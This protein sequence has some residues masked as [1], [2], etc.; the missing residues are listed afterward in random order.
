M[1]SQSKTIAPDYLN[2]DPAPP[3][4]SNNPNFDAPNWVKK[5]EPEV[6]RGFINDVVHALKGQGVTSFAVTRYCFGGRYAIDFAIDQVVD[7]VIVSH[8][9]QVEIPKTFK[10][11]ARFAKAPLLLEMGDQD[12]EVDVKKQGEIDDILGDYAHGHKRE[13]WPGC[14]HGFA[15]RADILDPNNSRVKRGHSRAVLHGWRSISESHLS[16]GAANAP[17]DEIV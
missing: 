5:Y 3:Y 6:T 14:G 11:F 7:V 13:C 12:R 10:D 15:V 8:L 17:R 4:A 9:S 1:T 2:G 16:S